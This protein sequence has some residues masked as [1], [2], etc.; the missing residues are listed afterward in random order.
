MFVPRRPRT[1]KYVKKP[2]A[3]RGSLTTSVKRKTFY[4]SRYAKR[5]AR[6]TGSRINYQVAKAVSRAMNQVSENKIVSLTKVDEAGPTAIQAG[7]NVFTK[8]FTI[9]NTPTPWSAT[10]GLTPIGGMEFPLGDTH[11]DRNGKYIYLQKTHLTMKIDMDSVTNFQF[12][13]DFRVICFKSRRGNNPI[14]LSNR[15]DQTLFLDTNGNEFGHATTGILGTDIMLQP[16]NKKDWVVYSDKKFTLTNP[17]ISGSDNLMGY[18]GRYAVNKTMSFNL[19]Y[20]AKAEIS[21]VSNAPVDLD[22]NYVIVCYA[23][24]NAQDDFASKWEVSL[25]GSTTFKD[26]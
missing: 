2:S 12:P 19:P 8:S 7:N 25:R 23:S 13:C 26:N 20:F 24:M 1:T 9:G 10:A 15:Y 11:S 21:A 5:P 22:T 16:I 3:A 4:K 6:L 18:A 17:A 14:G